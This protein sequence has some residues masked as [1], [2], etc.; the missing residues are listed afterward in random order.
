[1]KRIKKSYAAA[2]GIVLIV[3]IFSGVRFRYLGRDTQNLTPAVARSV[4]SVPKAD[5]DNQTKIVLKQQGSEIMGTGAQADGRKVTITKGGTY[6]VSGTLEEGQILIDAEEKDTVILLMQDVEL[7]NS[8]ESVIQAD[9]VGHLSIQFEKDS[10]NTFQSGKE[11]DVTEA[12]ANEDAKGAAIY[13]HGGLS[14]TG[15]GSCKILGYLNNGI[16][17]KGNLLL[18]NGVLTI[19]ACNHAVK[20]KDSVEAAGGTISIL[21]GG[22]GMKSDNTAGGEYGNIFIT[23]GDFTI[24]SSQDAIQ[25]EN[26]LQISGGNF[27]VVTGGGSANNAYSKEKGME[28]FSMGGRNFGGGEGRQGEKPD[29]D[30]APSDSDFKKAPSGSDSEEPPTESEETNW[31][32]SETSEESRKGF[33]GGKNLVVSGGTFSIDTYDDAFHSN[34]DISIMAGDFSI[35]SGDDG[36][37]ADEELSIS[38]GTIKVTKSYEGLEGNQITIDKADIEITATDDG[39]NAYGG[40]SSM[41]GGSAK[42]TEEIPNLEILG[43]NLVVNADGDGLDSNGNFSIAGGNIVV[44]GPENS[45]NGA[46][47]AGSE[48]GGSC[49]ISGGTIIALG[50]A[51]MAEGFTEESK[52][53]SFLHNFSTSFEKGSKIVIKDSSGK[54]LYQYTAEK[55]GSSIVF[56]C[57]ELEQGKTCVVSVDGQEEEITMDSVAVSNGSSRGGFGRG[58]RNSFR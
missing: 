11:I 51:G 29:M 26:T 25:S 48:N 5:K 55:A 22:D 36:I 14:V 56:S 45:G 35:S 21:S 19:E 17:A 39:I 20:G 43:G 32:M 4:M 46:L 7:T 50:S 30:R 57:P 24:K 1:M 15:E 41:G 44:N 42:K 40:Q 58:A 18:H 28:H 47:D 33:K 10:E 31:D 27:E 38:G 23:D 9:S 16:Q 53:C 34:G 6:L 2:A 49:T 52:Q 3:L 8:T 12:E 13:S 37:H 54:K